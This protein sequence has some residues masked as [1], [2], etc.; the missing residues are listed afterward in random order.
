M[1]QKR[2]ILAVAL[3]TLLPHLG[4]SQGAMIVEDPG[5][6]LQQGIE[7]AE[8]FGEMMTQTSMFLED[9]DMKY[10]EWSENI[11][12][13]QKTIKLATTAGKKVLVLYKEIDNVYE[14][15]EYFRMN[16]K[17]S[18]YLSAS[19]KIVLYAEGAAACKHLMEE[20]EELIKRATE[21]ADIQAKQ[22]GYRSLEQIDKLIAMVRN[23]DRELVK[24]INHA[25]RIV[26][27]KRKLIDKT[28]AMHRMLTVKY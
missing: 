3:A 6:M 21:A 18:S 15:L 12:M 5:M 24:A 10:S 22:D 27:A 19:E 26:A 4:H 7:H 25:N 14:R 16:L 23:V 2:Y 17:K 8:S 11:K 13:Y 1:K 9:L 20:R 28:M